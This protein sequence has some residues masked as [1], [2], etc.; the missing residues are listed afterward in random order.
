M[1][2]FHKQDGGTVGGR[3]WAN[4]T[5]FEVSFDVFFK[6]LELDFGEAVDGAELRLGSFFQG[7]GVI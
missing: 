1:G 4:K 2:F 6:D 5:L 7:N 3:G